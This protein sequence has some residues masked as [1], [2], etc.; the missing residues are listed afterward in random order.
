MRAVVPSWSYKPLVRYTILCSHSRPRR[1]RRGWSR[2]S[3]CWGGRWWRRP[4]SRGPRT[5]CPRPWG[6]STPWTPDPSQLCW[7]QAA[8]SNMVIIIIFYSKRPN[9]KLKCRMNESDA[10]NII[11]FYC[12]YFKYIILYIHFFSIFCKLKIRI[13]INFYSY[14]SKPINW[15]LRLDNSPIKLV[16]GVSFPLS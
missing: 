11:V 9:T 4:W 6:S 14:Y 2:Q 10:F 12:Y 15:P 13:R 3:P 5:H 7:T 8:T 16:L 1:W